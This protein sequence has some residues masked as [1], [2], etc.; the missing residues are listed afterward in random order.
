MTQRQADLLLLTA[1]AV[2]GASFV[3]V[4]EALA[5]ASPLTFVAVRFAVAALVL[6]PFTDLR[7]PFS[8]R[9]L[10]AGL[11]L[12]GL[13]A[14]GF[15]TQAVGLV[16]TTPARSAFIVALS[17]VLAPAVAF[18]ALRQRQSVA[19]I[20]ALLVAGIG[21]YFLTAPETAGLS[22]GDAWT[23]ITAVVF[24]AQIVA[25]AEL[26]R[27]YDPRRL[28]WLQM[29]GTAVLI[30]AA[31]PLLETP[32]LRWSP[33]FAAALL[34][35]AVI[36][37]ALAF[38]W[39]MQAQRHMSSARAALIFCFEPVFAAAA[40]WLWLGE[41]LAASQWIGGGLILAGMVLADAPLS[42]RQ[43]ASR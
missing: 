7:T 12:T 33:G 8:R 25:V 21:V 14:S 40:S 35:A 2:W 26:S 42:S 3:V 43:G 41:T 10:G 23:L 28:V 19:V 15:A 17:S 32:M 27:R 9:E 39:Q 24:G 6:T 4:K 16:H 29:A 5:A 1:T 38:I 20:A 31:A 34:Y 37:T 30:G 22:R 18:F 36:A 11:L 13:L